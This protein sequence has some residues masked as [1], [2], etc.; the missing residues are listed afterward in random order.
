MT[1]PYHAEP[2]GIFTG[3]GG[4][5]SSIQVIIRI[6]GMTAPDF[7]EEQSALCP[8]PPPLKNPRC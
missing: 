5:M 2:A 7:R 4:K 3:S 1:T 8:I 6:D